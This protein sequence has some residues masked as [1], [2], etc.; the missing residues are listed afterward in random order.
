MDYEEYIKYHKEGDANV[1]ERLI[2]KLAKHLNLSRWDSFRLVYYYSIT[3]NIPSALDLL[4]NPNKPKEQLKFRTDRRWVRQENRFQLLIEQLSPKLMNELDELKTTQE[5][6]EY[7][8]KW[9][10]FARYAVFLFLEVWNKFNEK[11]IIDNLKLK[12]EPGE[13]YTKGA[14]IVAGTKKIDKLTEFIERCK[15]DTGDDIFSIE[16]SLCAV[17]KIRKGTR[18]NGYYTVRLLN[19]I[20]NSKWE[21]L[22]LQL[23]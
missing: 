5:Q 8:V 9:Y 7:V 2:Q 10:Y 1:E 12:F 4:E 3:Y 23:L 22:I 6:Y 19:D 13:N 21:S 15:Q 20:E 11:E 16:T 18:Y 14:E 17:E